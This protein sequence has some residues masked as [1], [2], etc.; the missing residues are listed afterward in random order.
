[1]S[2]EPHETKPAP[3]SAVPGQAT[4]SPPPGNRVAALLLLLWICAAVGA[5]RGGLARYA[6]ELPGALPNGVDPNVAPW[7]ELTILPD[8]GPAIAR[9]IVAH[10]EVRAAQAAG[11]SQVFAAPRDMEAVSGIGKKTAQRLAPFLRFD[12]SSRRQPASQ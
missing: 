12:D 7:W 8:V 3:A 9:R 2:N 6:E 5:A 11:G 4:L 10:R 1:V